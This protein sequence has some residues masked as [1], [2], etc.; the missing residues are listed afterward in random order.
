MK[1]DLVKMPKS[2]FVRV[3]CK[4]CKND[5]VIFNKAAT[6][7]KCT[8]CGEDLAVSTG[9]VTLIKGKVLEVLS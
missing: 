9:G 4:K 1:K 6:A 8:N 3:L 2:H 7:I 5:Q